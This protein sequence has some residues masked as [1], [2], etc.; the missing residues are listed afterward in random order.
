M[1]IYK[2]VKNVSY[3]I[4]RKLNYVIHQRV[5]DHN[6]LYI[7]EDSLENKKIMR[8]LLLNVVETSRGY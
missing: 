8:V 4:F 2:F 7:S 6:V 1:N 3:L 5:Q